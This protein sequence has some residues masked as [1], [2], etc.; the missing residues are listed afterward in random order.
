MCQPKPIPAEHNAKALFAPKRDRVYFEHGARFPFRGGTAFDGVN[1]WWAAELCLLCYVPEAHWVREHLA[2]AGFQDVEVFERD[3]THAIWADGLLAFRGTAG[4]K[5]WLADLDAWLTKDGSGR[6]HRGFQ[7]T[8]DH[9]WDAVQERVGASEVH[10]SGHSMGGAL[11]TLAAKRLPGARTVT[12]FGAPRPGNQEF[13][14]SIPCPVFRVVNNNDMVARLPLSMSY[15]HVGDLKYFDARG[16]LHEDPAL[17]DRLKSRFQG[18]QQQFRD[19]WA[20]W[21]TKRFDSVA[22]NPLI[23]HSPLHYALHAWNHVIDS[24]HA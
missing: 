23:D 17:W 19:N 18:H 14:D 9:A 22:Y 5:D 10:L 13:A 20:L 8:L 16:G 2:R 7:T 1:T 4:R 15:R 3:G 11:A 12:T 6:V 24:Q 21:R